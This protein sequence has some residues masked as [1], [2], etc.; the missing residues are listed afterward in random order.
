[1]F[2]EEAKAIFGDKVLSIDLDCLILKEFTSLITDDDFKILRGLCNPYNGSIW[3]VKP[4]IYNNM[5]NDL[6]P[7]TAK[8]SNRQKMENG[9]NFYGSDQA[10]MA[11]NI[12][13]APTWGEKDGIYQYSKLKRKVIPEDAK[14]IFFAGNTKPWTSEF[15]N[16]Y[17]KNNLK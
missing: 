2:S 9:K 1:M 13:D 4:G 14:I 10:Y 11:A 3:Q 16:T 6:T 5:W 15:K 17:W 8:L 7:R 12:P